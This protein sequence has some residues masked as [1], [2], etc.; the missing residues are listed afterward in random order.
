MFFP[1]ACVEISRINRARRVRKQPRYKGRCS[2]C[3]RICRKVLTLDGFRLQLAG[4]F[5]DKNREELVMK[6]YA[7]RAILRRL[8]RRRRLVYD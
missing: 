3:Y 8:L 4:D 1:W 5:V 7:G 6:L 2:H